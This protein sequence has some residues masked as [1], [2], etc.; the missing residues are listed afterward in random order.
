MPATAADPFSLYPRF[1]ECYDARC[2]R[3]SE[4]SVDRLSVL[5]LEGE[6]DLL[7]S[8]DLREI[9]RAKVANECPALAIDLSGVSYIDSSGLAT[10][11]EYYRD[12]MAF[13][14]K[15]ALVGLRDEVRTIFELTGLDELIPAY[16]SVAEAK[17]ALAPAS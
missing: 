11:V 1:Q 13:A 4:T 7:H 16:P 2:M 8:P 17:A 6:I 3:S 5:T 14:G 12:S 15:F 9:L 10:L